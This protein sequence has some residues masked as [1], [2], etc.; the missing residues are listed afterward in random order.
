MAVQIQ[1]FTDS[2]VADYPEAIEFMNKQQE[3]YWPHFEVKVEKDKQ[4]FMVNLSEQEKHGVITTLQ[5]FTKYEWIIGN[6][7]WINFV[8]RKFP[9]PADIQPMAATFGAVE[10]GIHQFFYKKLNEVLGLANDEFYRAYI[11][12]PEL[13]A[14]IDFL[15]E[16]LDEADDL[17]ALGGFTFGEGA[18]LYTSFAYL[19]HFQSS[20]KNKLVNVV[21]GINFSARDEHLHSLA[22]AWLFRTL[23]AEKRA[24]GEI[25]PEEEVALQKDIFAA[26]QKVLEHEQVIIAKIFEKGTIDGI[27]AHQLEEFAKHR[28]NLCL[29]NLGYESLFEIKNTVVEEWFYKGITGYASNDFFNSK[30]NQYSRDWNLMGFSRLKR[31]EQ[32]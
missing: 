2:F 24:A 23:L 15:T 18:I 19:K 12:D 1:T 26:A 28:I 21:S 30:G 16:T 27:T 32:Q 9:R 7:F 5:L 3:I 22:A 20:G 17:R 11:N 14:R 31:K 29:N 10:M 4:D 6:E 25:T 13:K 8:M